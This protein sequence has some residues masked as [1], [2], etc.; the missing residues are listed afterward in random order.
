VILPRP[1]DDRSVCIGIAITIADVLPCDT[2]VWST[3]FEPQVDDSK[4][5]WRWRVAAI[6]P[7]RPNFAASLL[8]WGVPP[9][10]IR[11]PPHKLSALMR[12]LVI[13]P[14]DPIALHMTNRG[15]APRAFRGALMFVGDP[16]RKPGEL[17]ARIVEAIVRRHE[18]ADV[19]AEAEGAFDALASAMP[20]IAHE[21]VCDLCGK[22]AVDCRRAVEAKRGVP[23]GRRRFCTGRRN[24]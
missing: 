8:E 18:G 23:V 4:R 6:L 24:Q 21:D 15:D 20:E 11:D 1:E 3:T 14:G 13:R 5:A 10:R 7:S 2:G 12:A 16:P 22:T 17:A 9:C 19:E